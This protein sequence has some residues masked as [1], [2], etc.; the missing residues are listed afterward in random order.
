MQIHEPMTVFTDYLLG[1]WTAWLGWRLWKEGKQLGDRAISSWS[2]V[3]LFSAVAA[4]FGGTAHG[5][6]ERL[7]FAGHALVWKVTVQAV[8]IA[9]LSF[10]VATIFVAFRGRTRQ[11]LL[12]IA[13]FKWLAYAIWMT[14]HNAFRYVV[15]DYLP[16]LLFA[17]AVHG[18]LWLRQGRSSGRAIMLGVLVSLGAAA[19]QVA[20]LAPHPQFNHNDLYHVV[21]M[22]AFYLLYRG[23]LRLREAV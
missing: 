2:L 23:G 21:Q 4:F 22:V 14:E 20:G 16:S 19:I 15:Y 13:L 9:S 12:V 10:L 17:G 5:F 7:G 8:G 3:F 11:A 18:W 6:P 1:G